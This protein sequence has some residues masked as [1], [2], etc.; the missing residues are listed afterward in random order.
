M[1]VPLLTP[2]YVHWGKSA[3]P[4]GQWIINV[5]EFFLDIERETGNGPFNPR[6]TKS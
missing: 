6:E 1:A 5:L 4:I 2:A 3:K